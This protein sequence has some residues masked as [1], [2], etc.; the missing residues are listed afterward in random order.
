MTIDNGL[1]AADDSRKISE[2][3]LKELQ[4]KCSELA[5]ELI[6]SFGILIQQWCGLSRQI[7]EIDKLIRKQEKE[8]SA[9]TKIYRS[10]P[11]VGS[12]SARVLSSELG[13]LASRFKNERELFS[14]TG[15][16]PSEHSFG[17]CVRRGRISRCGPPRIRSR[18]IN[19]Q[20][21]ELNHS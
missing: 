20:L 6:F 4:A 3:Y 14:Y 1:M 2:K 16:T 13:D 8:N 17:D 5:E 7:K 15:L 18:F 9:E 12:T 21:Y 10:V 19:S 11:G